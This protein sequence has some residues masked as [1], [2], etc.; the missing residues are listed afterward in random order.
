[1][2]DGSYVAVRINQ[3]VSEEHQ[4]GLSVSELAKKYGVCQTMI[5]YRLKAHERNNGRTIFS[6]LSIRVSNRLH[7]AGFTSDL[8]VIQK[9]HEDRK[10]FCKLRNFGKKSFLELEEWV[11]G[12]VSFESL[13]NSKLKEIK[14]LLHDVE[15]LVNSNK[16]AR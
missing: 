5:R 11:L 13:V 15:R 10:F 16:E 1:M 9:F 4:S 14:V 3:K 12:G 2:S 6:G 7:E 8:A